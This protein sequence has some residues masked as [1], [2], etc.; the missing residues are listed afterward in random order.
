[1]ESSSEGTANSNSNSLVSF[2]GI[3]G[4]VSKFNGRSNIKRFLKDFN[5]RSKIEGW[6]DDLKAE[7]LKCLCTE[8]AG[9]F[10]ESRPELENASF[11]EIEEA[12]RVCKTER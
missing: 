1:M 7:I 11:D 12:L 4:K 6:N 10:L 5:S 9:S 3:L 8:S 2:S